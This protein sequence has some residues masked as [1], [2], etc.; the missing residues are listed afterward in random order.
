MEQMTSENAELREQVRA[1][2]TRA[3]TVVTIGTRLART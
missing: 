1:R 2:Y 3:A